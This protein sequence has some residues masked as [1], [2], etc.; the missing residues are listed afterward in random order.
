MHYESLNIR[1][2]NINMNYQTKCYDQLIMNSDF[3]HLFLMNIVFCRTIRLYI[4]ADKKMLKTY[5]YEFTEI[6]VYDIDLINI[7]K[8]R[9]K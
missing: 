8:T 9:S 1:N 5:Q 4:H 2:S 6:I 3:L 7:E